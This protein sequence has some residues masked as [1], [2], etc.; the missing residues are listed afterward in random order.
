MDWFRA[1]MAYLRPAR[2]LLVCIGGLSGTGK[3]TVAAELAADIGAAPGALHVR[4]DIERK[5]LAGVEETARLAAEHYSREASFRVY[6]ACLGRAESALRAGHSVVIDAV[7][8]RAEERRAVEDLARSCNVGFTAVWLEAPPDL[9]KARVA[10]RR[11]D[12]SDATPAVVEM[13]TSYDLGPLQW[14]RISAAGTPAETLMGVRGTL[15]SPP[16]GPA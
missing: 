9:L 13:Q 1:A 15:L 11:G 2:P 3:S 4:S 14:P 12:A 16:G 10:A 5:V 7:F 6:E 8:A